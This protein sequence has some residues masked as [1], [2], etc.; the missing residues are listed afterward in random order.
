MALAGGSLVV[1]A[2]AFALLYGA[3]NGLSTIARGALPLVLF[4]PG[5][6]GAVV[7][8]LL[9]PSF[10]VSAVAPLAYALVIE[11]GARGAWLLSAAVAAA[12]LGAAVALA[13]RFGP[14][15]AGAPG[16]PGG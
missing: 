2:A 14:R 1:P 5:A 6:Y 13:A 7:G 10:L 3:G 15:S 11:R 12:A 9:V 16:A 8:R 4:E